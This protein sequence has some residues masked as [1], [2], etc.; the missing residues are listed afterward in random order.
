MRSSNNIQVPDIVSSDQNETAPKLSKRVDPQL[1]PA[2]ESL[3]CLLSSAPGHPT[4]Q[5]LALCLSHQGGGKKH[6][7]RAGC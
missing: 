2:L 3:R 7:S 6:R 5:T 4:K 1:N